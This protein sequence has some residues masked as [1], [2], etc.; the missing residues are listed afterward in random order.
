MLIDADGFLDRQRESCANEADQSHR[1]N[2]DLTDM[3]ER[4]RST[5]G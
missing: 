3:G 4:W 1:S 2:G 5:A